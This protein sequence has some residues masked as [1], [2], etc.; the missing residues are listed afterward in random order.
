MGSLL[1]RQVAILVKQVD[2]CHWTIRNR[3][4]GG[5]LVP[6]VSETFPA[7]ARHMVPKRGAAVRE[8]DNSRFEVLTGKER[9]RNGCKIRQTAYGKEKE[10]RGR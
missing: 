10:E 8:D 9:G 4:E 2:E 6:E 5:A 3:P 7:N 1:W